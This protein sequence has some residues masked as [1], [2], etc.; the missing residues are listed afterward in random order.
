MSVSKISKKPLK[1]SLAL[2]SLIFSLLAQA[3]NFEGQAATGW[4]WY[5][6]P[7]SA[8]SR[9]QQ[10]SATPLS[11][12]ARMENLQAIIDRALKRSILDPTP[13][14]IAHYINLQNQMADT[15]HRYAQSWSAVL[16][17]QPQLDYSLIQPTNSAGR[18]VIA[19]QTLL[20]QELAL[21]IVAESSGL[22]FF[23]RGDCP[24]CHRFAPILKQF[25]DFYD[26]EVLAVS[27]DGGLLAEFPEPIFDTEKAQLL[28]VTTVPALFAANPASNT[29]VPIAFGLVSEDVLRERLVTQLLPEQQRLVKQHF[30][31]AIGEPL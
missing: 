12:E 8:P 6:D 18:E 10:A 24:Y 20:E 11:V 7:T 3:Q 25:S 29:I 1:I 23:Y 9:P 14:N 5:F 19:A 15:A 30:D 28:K 4:S 31:Q 21:E 22:I 17:K 27:L 13:E 26:I 2:L 16:L